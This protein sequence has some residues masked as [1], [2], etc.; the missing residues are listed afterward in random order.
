MSTLIFHMA[1]HND[2]VMRPIDQQLTQR[3]AAWWGVI[4]CSGNAESNMTTVSTQT[5]NAQNKVQTRRQE[6]ED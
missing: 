6:E 3:G 2:S 4:Q 5:E 1:A